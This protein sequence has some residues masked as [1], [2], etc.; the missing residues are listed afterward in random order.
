MTD[1]TE[2]LDQLKN[3]NLDSLTI[4]KEH[5]LEFRK[6]LVARED[7]KHYRGVAYHHGLTI[8]TYTDEPSK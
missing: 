5:F 1:Y 3:G 8:Y 4:E 2:L 7:F 6:V